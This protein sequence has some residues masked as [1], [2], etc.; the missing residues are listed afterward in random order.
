MTVLLT[1]PNSIVWTELRK[2]L[3]TAFGETN[4][5]VKPY[6]PEAEQLDHKEWREQRAE[7]LAK[8]I[9]LQSKLRES[10]IPV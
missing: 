1:L 3:A 4:F 10:G 9:S 8:V 7:L 6:D 2:T 5:Q